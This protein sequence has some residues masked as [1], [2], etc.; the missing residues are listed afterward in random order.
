VTTVAEDIR[1][2]VRSDADTVVARQAGRDA[3]LELGFSRT[4]ATF[5]A[6]AIS[7]IARN[8][9]VHA[10]EGEVII[11]EVRLES[12]I[13]LRVVARDAGPGIQDVD[14][15]MRQDYTS[16]AGLGMG[17]WGAIRLMDEVDVASEPGRG[18]TVTMTK[19][20]G[21]DEVEEF[22]RH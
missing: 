13:G 6:T 18:T 22:L 3:A 10:G 1:V 5:I 9:T 7:E 4:D 11:C 16:E 8:I 20:R 2:V 14:A 21:A 17:I 12:R 19:W 15:V